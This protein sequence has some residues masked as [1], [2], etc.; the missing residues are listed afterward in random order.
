MNVNALVDYWQYSEEL[1]T[2]Y[3]FT[4]EDADAIAAMGWTA[5]RL[6]VSWSRVEPAPGQ[7]DEAYLDEVA[8]AVAMLRERNVYTILD[9]HQDAWDA[10][11]AA[12][13]DEV[14]EGDSV[15]AGGWDGA[16]AW[17]TFDGGAARCESGGQREF[18]PAVRAA[19]GS[20]FDDVEGPGGVS[21][22]TRYIQMFAHLVSRF[23]N[24]DAVAGYDLMNE[25]NAFDPPDQPLLSAFYKN[26]LTRDAASR[27]GGLFAPH[28]SRRHQR[29]H[30]RGRVWARRRRSFTYLRR[31]TGAHR[32]VG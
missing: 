6:L 16:P 23:A 32:R 30:A 22:Q 28:L 14:C 25:P 4:A 7:Y 29:R 2:T 27:A 17:A 24:D 8:A 13:P 1:F 31:G 5:V 19:W 18:G 3:A 11:L 26:A 20:F 9:L 10:S 15:P 12:S 21:L